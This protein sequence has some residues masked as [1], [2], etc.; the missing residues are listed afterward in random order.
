M[1]VPKTPATLADVAAPIRN[2][3]LCLL[4][5]AAE[6]CRPDSEPAKHSE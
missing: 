1:V 4:K 6:P 2:R 3:K 5:L